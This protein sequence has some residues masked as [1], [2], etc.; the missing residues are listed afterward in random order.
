[1][2]NLVSSFLHGVSQDNYENKNEEFIKP[3]PILLNL[4]NTR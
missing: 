3:S 4:H 1:M 2:Y